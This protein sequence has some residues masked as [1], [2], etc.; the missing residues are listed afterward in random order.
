M[1]LQAASIFTLVSATFIQAVYNLQF[2]KFL[3]I[4]LRV[5]CSPHCKSGMLELHKLNLFARESY[6]KCTPLAPP[7][8]RQYVMQVR[9]RG[10][11]LVAHLVLEGV[12]GEGDALL[13]NVA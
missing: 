10:G 5:L 8:R 6:G 11:K 13:E 7:F 9:D 3:I 2:Q 4:S 12:E 1:A